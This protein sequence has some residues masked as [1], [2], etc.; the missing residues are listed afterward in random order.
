MCCLS[1]GGGGGGEASVPFIPGDSSGAETLKETERFEPLNPALTLS[2]G[3]SETA[4]EFYCSLLT[5]NQH[6]LNLIPL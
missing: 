1:R 2:S 3:S 6:N 4:F 5:L